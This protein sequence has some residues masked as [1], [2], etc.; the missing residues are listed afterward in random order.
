M[1]RQLPLGLGFPPDI[2]FETFIAG[3]NA[4]PLAEVAACAHGAG[5]GLVFIWGGAGV[6]KSHL[7]Q[8]ACRLADSQSRRVAYI[9]LGET[10]SLDP[11]MLEGLETSDL[12]ALDDI[13]AVAGEAGWEEALF[14]LFNR[15]RERDSH[16]LVSAN[17]S[18]AGLG[19]KLADLK[20]RLGSGPAYR[21]Q[22]LDD[23][24][25]LAALGQAA[26]R[27]GLELNAE[28]GRYL[29][30]RYSRD[31]HSLFDSLDRLDHAS[32]AAQRRL[33][34]PFVRE[35]LGASPKQHDSE[36]DDSIRAHS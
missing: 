27:R 3:H 25:A 31:L 19:L 12:I 8:A 22:R 24:G 14:D 20:T 9:P 36:H 5:Q 34:I 26:H 11:G 15:C 23:T 35:V 16:L 7:L 2:S 21:L 30:S 28:T 13:Q 18:P 10:G 32:L 6:G 29:L 1:I 33:T 4:E 17:A